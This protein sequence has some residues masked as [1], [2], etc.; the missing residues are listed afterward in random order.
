P[1]TAIDPRLRDRIYNWARRR[2]AWASALG[3]LAIFVLVTVSG[4]VFHA[5]VE[6]HIVGNAYDQVDVWQEQRT[7]LGQEIARLRKL[8]DDAQDPS[9][10]REALH[11]LYARDHVLSDMIRGIARGITGLTVYSPEDRAAS[12]LRGLFEEKIN[13]LMTEDRLVEVRAY[14]ESLRDVNDDNDLFNFSIED[15]EWIDQQLEEVER[16]QGVRSESG[17]HKSEPAIR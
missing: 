9:A 8:L 7:E 4:S 2:P 15:R 12:I 13:R 11:D 5:S 14:L 10:T 1:V 16:A 3:T 6:S 17:Q